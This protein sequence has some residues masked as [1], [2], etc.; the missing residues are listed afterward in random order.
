LIDQT[1]AAAPKRWWTKDSRISKTA[2]ELELAITETVKAAPGCEAFVGD[3]NWELRG[4]R[5]G[6]ADR[7]IAREALTPIVEQMQR[8]F[9]LPDG[10]T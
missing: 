1:P 3:V 2:E 10:P 7:K 9:R 4:T 8:E 6:Q 5:F